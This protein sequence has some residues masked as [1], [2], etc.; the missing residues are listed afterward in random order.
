M[1]KKVLSAILFVFLLGCFGTTSVLAEEPAIE[2]EDVFYEE[3]VIPVTLTSKEEKN[4]KKLGFSDEEINTMTEEE[5]EKY[6]NLDGK[7]IN[8]T[9]KFYKI[10]TDQDSITSAIVVSEKEALAQSG[11][12]ESAGEE[13]PAVEP[14]ISVMA[15][16]TRSTTWLKMTTSS[17][18]LS[19]GATLL[20]NS[21]VWLRNPN[22]ALSDVV[23]ITH[24][25]SAVKLAGTESFAY[26]YTDGLGVHTTGSTSTVRNSVG[27]AKK[28]NLKAIGTNA[29]PYNHNGYI[30][31]QVKKGNQYDIRANAYGHYAHL[32]AGVTG[33]TIGLSVGSLT[34]SYAF[35]YTRV[36][37]T[38]V[39]F[40]Y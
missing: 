13:P 31:V 20:K 5:F 38:M 40:S 25:A 15:V 32:T 24:S 33:G 2:T 16:D 21:F 28:F 14:G 9:D 10:T 35:R 30:S 37:D 23:G 7:L 39:T 3:L 11:Y 34:L 18:K 4:L 27:L 17:T 26:K 36:S 6:K 12:S 29:P 8:K 22:V 19:T 1:K